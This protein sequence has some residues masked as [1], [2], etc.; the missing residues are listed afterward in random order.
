MPVDTRGVGS[1]RWNY[2]QCESPDVG[3]KKLNSG[4]S[5]KSNTYFNL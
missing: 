2:R 4:T 3:A 1:L 5:G